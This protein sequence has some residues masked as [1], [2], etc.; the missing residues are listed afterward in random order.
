VT[1]LLEET[2]NREI[3]YKTVMSVFVNMNSLF[4]A[5][6]SAKQVAATTFI[7]N[8]TPNL[9]TSKNSGNTTKPCT[10]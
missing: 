4:E 9:C 10:A 7:L 3:E 6:S 2:K 1:D 5:R 8:F